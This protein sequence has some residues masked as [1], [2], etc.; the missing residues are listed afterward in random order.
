MNAF[1]L[2]NYSSLQLV[3]MPS[4]KNDCLSILKI[5]L[6]Q[7]QY[8]TIP[9]LFNTANNFQFELKGFNIV[10]LAGTDGLILLLLNVN[11]EITIKVKQ[12]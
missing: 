11:C 2:G 3:L 1:R 12:A 4:Y 6:S 5:H 10:H 8:S 9:L 7:G